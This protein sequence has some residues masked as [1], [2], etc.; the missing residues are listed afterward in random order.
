MKL[1]LRQGTLP[2]IMQQ[3]K[4]WSVDIEGVCHHSPNSILVLPEV[5]VQAAIVTA[6][7][8][9]TPNP[10]TPSC[11]AFVSGQAVLGQVAV[12]VTPETVPPQIVSQ[13]LVVHCG[14]LHTKLMPQYE[15]PQGENARSTS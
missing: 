8:A 14:S 3:P 15:T 7:T 4:G 5:S 10:K 9:C 13:G 11:G 2:P 1:G 6:V 12:S